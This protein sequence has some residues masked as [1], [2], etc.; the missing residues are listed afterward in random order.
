[1]VNGLWEYL[2]LN[3]R[4]DRSRREHEVEMGVARRESFAESLERKK[5]ELRFERVCAR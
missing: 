3:L 2:L 4:R 1:M 5:G